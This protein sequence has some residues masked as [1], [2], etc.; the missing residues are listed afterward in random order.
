MAAA[1]GAGEN[2]KSFVA[3]RKAEYRTKFPFLT[4]SQVVAKLK[5]LWKSQKSREGKPT[6]ACEII[7]P[8]FLFLKVN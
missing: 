7:L 5:R 8:L 1:N 3:R 6:E 2:V 4:D